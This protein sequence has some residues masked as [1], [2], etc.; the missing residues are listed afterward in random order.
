[1][2]P[3]LRIRKL[4]SE[5]G[6]HI[7]RLSRPQDLNPGLTTQAQS[8]LPRPRIELLSKHSRCSSEHPLASLLHEPWGGLR[9]IFNNI[10]ASSVV[11]GQFGFLT[12]ALKRDHLGSNPYSATF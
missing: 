9:I 3:I 11:Q 12:L 1:M 5:R 7:Y 6:S 4:S 8:R 10:L 2:T